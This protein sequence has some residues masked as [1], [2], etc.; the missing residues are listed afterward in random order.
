MIIHIKCLELFSKVEIKILWPVFKKNRLDTVMGKVRSFGGHL[1]LQ[2][3]HLDHGEI[4]H[5]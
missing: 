4:V 2:M 3:P 1:Q 5:C